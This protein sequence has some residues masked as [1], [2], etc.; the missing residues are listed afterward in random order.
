MAG[1]SK[2]KGKK[3]K[4]RDQKDDG[5]RFNAL[6]GAAAGVLIATIGLI[7]AI[8]VADITEPDTVPAVS[9]DCTD[10]RQQALDIYQQHPQINV[11]Y[12]GEL[13]AA[14]QINEVIDAVKQLQP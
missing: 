8:V 12:V 4:K 14:C 7:S 5:S 6:I 9:F 3:R 2:K 13:E 10:E 1:A 11:P